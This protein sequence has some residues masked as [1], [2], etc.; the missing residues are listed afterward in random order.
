MTTDWTP[1][2]GRVSRDAPTWKAKRPMRIAVLGDF[3]GGA[4]AGR[5][6]TGDA[7]GRR[8]PMRVEFDT[9]DD[10]L[11]RLNL[12]V[13]LPLGPEGATV[14]VTLSEL[15][16]FH[17]DELY[18]NV[19]LF[20]ALAALR[21][22]LNNTATFAAAAASMKD[23]ALDDTPA[24]SRSTRQAR[25]RGAAP[26]AGAT[27]DDFAR[28]T[29]RPAS[30]G[31]PAAIDALLRRVVAPFVVPAEASNKDRLVA[32]V[33]QA[34]SD[35]MRALL[36]QP[37]FQNLESLWRGADFLLRRLE[38]GPQLQVHLIDVSA[39]EFAADLSSGDD[40]SATG[41]YQLLVEKPSEEADGGFAFIAA[42]YR[43]EATP[44][45]AELL[46]RAARL[47]SH[48][49]APLIAAIEP[50]A[51][52]DRREP[53][54][55]LVQAAFGALREL[56]EAGWLA[57]MAPR[58]LLRHPY[59]KKSDPISSFAFEEFTPASGLRGMLWG[60]PALLAACVLGIRGG[61]L[62]IGDLPFHH[63][64][65]KDGDSVALPCTER[66]VGTDVA[67]LLRD[68]GINAVMAHK[69]E[70]M[71]RLSGLETVA[72]G[73]VASP[74]APP[75]R[76]TG[77]SRVG[78]G[79]AGD[80]ARVSTDWRGGREAAAGTVALSGPAQRLAEDSDDGD[81]A[82]AAEEAASAD[83]ELDDLLA[84]LD[85][86]PDGGDAPADAPPADAP[87]E[88]AADE[89]DELAKLLASLDEDSA[90]AEAAP[91]AEVGA[92]GEEEMDPELKALLASLG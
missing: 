81:A 77:D 2:F 48:A 39:E 36:H 53:P 22:K 42:C 52:A 65:D 91:A 67:T 11:G 44:P 32:A 80:K 29:G 8:K 24:L 41:L 46:G 50:E 40:L 16:S 70:A 25:A 83:A 69:G 17:P 12:E 64:V 57:L 3:G 55:R 31:E 56:P 34:L 7:L 30:R 58:F 6:D 21:K 71:V 75:A 92:A 59:G 62:T 54:H 82:P 23:W 84:S 9:L 89:D 61:Q 78:I 4:L 86:A 14:P 37:D 49:G 15:E 76:A 87:A 79:A 10:A 18:R 28:L 1:D 85:A 20:S 26:S 13:P 45:H 33:D 51:F 19:E 72:G 60:H 47:A 74:Q 5:L 43:F 27:L 73:D 88:A 35:A 63:V 68:W 66:M 38:T 90:P